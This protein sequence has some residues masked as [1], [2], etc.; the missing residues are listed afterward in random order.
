MNSFNQ[1]GITKID[2]S[3]S[4]QELSIKDMQKPRIV[5]FFQILRRKFFKLAQLNLLHFIFN[6]PAFVLAEII[7]NALAY[8]YKTNMG[9]NVH[10]WP[11]MFMLVVCIPAITVGPSQAGFTFVLRN[12]AREENA[13]IWYDYKQNALKNFKQGII[14]S[15]INLLV[16]VGLIL[17]ISFYL[18][19]PHKNA[20]VNIVV[21][22]QSI[23]FVF[24]LMMNLYI[25]P[26]LVTFKLK[27]RYIYKNA[28][29]FAV[30]K[31]LTNF[32]VLA[33]CFIIAFITMLNFF[34]GLM[35]LPFFT[36]SITGFICNFHAYGTIKKYMMD[37]IQ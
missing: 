27:T 1:Y 19:M 29:I 13:F 16:F 34:I 11:V 24:Y 32:I 17:S 14:I 9:L 37:P 21:C 5:V 28:L 20:I 15:G 30:T 7:C 36:L 6:I 35:L 2:I 18:S 22:L 33:V 10:N 8:Y 3:K 23:A 26:M 31:F 12:F 4:E 25:Y